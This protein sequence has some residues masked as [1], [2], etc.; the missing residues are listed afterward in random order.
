[1]AHWITGWHWLPADGRLAHGDGRAPADGEVVV[2][3]GP[4]RMCQRGLHA[5]P[6]VAE[7]D[8]YRPSGPVVLCRVLLDDPVVREDKMVSCRRIIVA[9]IDAAAVRP[10]REV[11]AAAVLDLMEVA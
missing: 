2:V 9:R 8:R 4:V 1:M 10:A 6:T 3:R 11:Y 5:S 7:A